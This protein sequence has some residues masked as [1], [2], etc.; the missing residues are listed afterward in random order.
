M[1][2][3]SPRV[4]SNKPAVQSC[5][6]ASISKVSAMSRPSIVRQ[7]Q[8][9]PLKDFNERVRQLLKDKPDPRKATEKRKSRTPNPLLPKR[10][11]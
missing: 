3:H 5:E 10:D 1:H 7:S 6:Q 11:G 2:G 4:L 8:H 9:I